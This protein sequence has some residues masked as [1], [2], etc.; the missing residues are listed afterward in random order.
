MAEAGLWV[1]WGVPARGREKQAFETLTEAM[2]YLDTLRGEGKIER[3]DVVVLTPQ[4]SELGGFVLIQGTQQQIDSLRREEEF[5][6]WVAR[7]QMVADKFGIVDVY[8]DQGLAPA[9]KRYQN[10][11]KRLG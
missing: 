2:S 10:A 3:S 5:Q 9:F 8:V 11:L 6:T 4:S 7:V 1:A